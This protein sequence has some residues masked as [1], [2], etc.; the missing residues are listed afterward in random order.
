VALFGRKQVKTS[1]S[2]N[3]VIK[4]TSNWKSNLTNATNFE[5]T[6]I[7]QLG[8]HHLGL[9]NAS[10]LLVIRLHASNEVRLALVKGLHET[11][12]RRLEL[13]AESRLLLLGLTLTVVFFNTH[14]EERRNERALG[15]VDHIC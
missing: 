11:F 4:N 1:V 14:G 3:E 2:E 8:E 6:S 12:K 10:L 5:K 7:S 9:E 13:E 15:G